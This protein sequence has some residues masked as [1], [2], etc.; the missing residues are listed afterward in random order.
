[1]PSVSRSGG[2]GRRIEL[3]IPMRIVHRGAARDD[4][5]D[6]ED[7]TCYICANTYCGDDEC[8]RA[9]THLACCTQSICCGCLLKGSKRCTC[10]DECDA[11]VSLCPFCREVSPVEAL[12]LFLAT[13]APCTACAKADAATTPAPSAADD[14]PAALAP[15]DET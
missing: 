11:V 12:D 9:M 8:A 3:S 2:A 1:M 10:K 7:L 13:K 5:S 15:I 14:P 4:G 6:D